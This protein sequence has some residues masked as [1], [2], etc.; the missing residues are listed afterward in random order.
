MDTA[1]DEDYSEK[2]A[3]ILDLKNVVELEMGH[4][5]YY[6]AC[7]FVCFYRVALHRKNMQLMYGSILYRNLKQRK[8]T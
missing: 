6:C 5:T 2:L 4:V 3:T 8:C 7:A 1:S